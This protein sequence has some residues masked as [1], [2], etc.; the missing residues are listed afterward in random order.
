MLTALKALWSDA[1]VDRNLL[2][3]IIR[4]PPSVA[5][6]GKRRIMVVRPWLF[7]AVAKEAIQEV[8]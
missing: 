1:L 6:Y 3:Q 8:T 4:S 2:F 5:F 7:H